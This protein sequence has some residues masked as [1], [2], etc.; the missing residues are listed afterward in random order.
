MGDL[1]TNLAHA[2]PLTPTMRHHLICGTYSRPDKSI[3][4]L[5]KKITT[6]LGKK[7]KNPPKGDVSI[8]AEEGNLSLGSGHLCL[9]INVLAKAGTRKATSGEVLDGVRGFRSHLCPCS[10]VQEEKE[11]IS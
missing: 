11:M 2:P 7:K 8:I 6:M 10:G 4:V 3:F 1:L 9:S 5:Q